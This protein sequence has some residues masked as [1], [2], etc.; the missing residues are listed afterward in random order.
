MSRGLITAILVAIL[1]VIGILLWRSFSSPA[2]DES[3]NVSEDLEIGA[4][5]APEIIVEDTPEE[6]IP[7][8][9][10]N[11]AVI[12]GDVSLEETLAE[13]VEDMVQ[14]IEERVEAIESEID[15]TITETLENI[16]NSLDGAADLISDLTG[17]STETEESEDTTPQETIDEGQG[18]EAIDEGRIEAEITEAS[19]PSEGY[20]IS[21]F[22]NMPAEAVKALL[23][24]QIQAGEL[25]AEA[26]QPILEA[27]GF[28]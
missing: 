6:A 4:E 16:D 22:E 10:G 20:D 17:R 15:E 7:E 23:Q 26:E 18:T 21:V 27:L 24:T 28:N 9:D 19:E 25:P 8:E 13:D 5:S 11:D 14:E 2:S 12:D 1:I 3:V